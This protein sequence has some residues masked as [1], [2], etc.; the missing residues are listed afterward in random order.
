MKK[1]IFAIVM[2]LCLVISA[3]QVFELSFEAH[4]FACNCGTTTT[5]HKAWCESLCNCSSTTA[6]S[7]QETCPAYRCENAAAA[8]YMGC[9]E[10]ASGRIDHSRMCRKFIQACP[11]VGGSTGCTYTNGVWDHKIGCPLHKRN[12]TDT[13]T[14][15]CMSCGWLFGEHYKYCIYHTGYNQLVEVINHAIYMPAVYCFNDADNQTAAN[16]KPGANAASYAVSEIPSVAASIG[17]NS[18]DVKVIQDAYNKSVQENSAL[19]SVKVTYRKLATY[20][21]YPTDGTTGERIWNNIHI[22]KHSIVVIDLNGNRI[23]GDGKGPVI[24]N[25]GTLIILDSRPTITC[26]GV[27]Q[28]RGYYYFDDQ[29]G[30]YFHSVRNAENAVWSQGHGGNI[31]I[32]G[33]LI[34]GGRTTRNNTKNGGTVNVDA[35]QTYEELIDSSSGTTYGVEK[36]Y[37][38]TYL[39]ENSLTGSRYGFGGGGIHNE[40][41]VIMNGGNIVGCESMDGEGAAINNRGVN[42]KFVMNDGNI[43]YNYGESIIHAEQGA[44]IEINSGKIFRNVGVGNG[45]VRGYSPDTNADAT[46][47]IGQTTDTA[48]YNQAILNNLAALDQSAIINMGDQ[49]IT[50]TGYTGKA[51]YLT[52]AQA[53]QFSTF[54]LTKAEVPL[55]A[56]NRSLAEI[57]TDGNGAGIYAESCILNLNAAII[58][59]N[60]AHYRGGGLDIFNEGDVTLSGNIIIDSNY[61]EYKGGGI[62]VREPSNKSDELYLK[63]TSDTVKVTNNIAAYGGGIYLSYGD[64]D[65]S[66]GK[67]LNNRSIGF[68]MSTDDWNYPAYT[69]YPMN[70]TNLS[71]G[72]KTVVQAIAFDGTVTDLSADDKKSTRHGGGGIFM[73]G[74]IN[75]NAT[76]SG[77]TTEISGNS[78]YNFGGGM[79]LNKGNVIMNG[80]LFQGNY[81]SGATIAANSGTTTKGVD[82]SKGGGLCIQDGSFKMNGGK[83]DGNHVDS[84]AGDG[85][86]IYV[87]AYSVAQQY[88]YAFEIYGGE[89]CNN[90]NEDD[91]GGG[92]M[93]LGNVKM[94]ATDP[95]KP[96]LVYDNTSCDNGGGFYVTE[97]KFDMY[98]GKIY[99]NTAKNY[100]GGGVYVHQS[101]F[102]MF[103]GEIYDNKALTRNGGGVY[104]RNGNFSMTSGK[105]YGNTAMNT[106]ST[107]TSSTAVG[108]QF[109]GGG[110]VCVQNGTVNITGDSQIYNNKAAYKG[111]AIYTFSSAGINTVSQTRTVTIGTTDANATQPKIYGNSVAFSGFVGSYILGG[112]GIC[113]EGKDS[114]LIVN[115]AEI[116]NNIVNAEHSDGGAILMLEGTTDASNTSSEQSLKGTSTVIINNVNAHHN[117]S[118]NDHGGFLALKNGTVTINDGKFYN[119]SALD[120]GGCIY[121]SNGSLTI[122]A[123]KDG[124]V[125]IYNNSATSYVGGAVYLENGII[126]MYG[127]NVYNNKVIN[128]QVTTEIENRGHGGAFDMLK[129]TFRMYNGAIY[130]NIA[131]EQVKG[132]GGAISVRDT[133]DVYI[134]GGKIGV[135]PTGDGTT[136]GNAARD[137]GAIFV[138]SGNIYI[139]K[140]TCDGSTDDF[141]NEQEP[142]DSKCGHPIIANN[143]ATSDG[144]A[145]YSAS[146]TTT[147]YCGEMT[148]NTAANKGGGMYVEGGDIRIENGKVK[149]NESERGEAFGDSLYMTGGD[150]TY[151]KVGTFG[152]SSGTTTGV[153]V[154]GGNLTLNT[155]PPVDSLISV[156]FKD[157]TTRDVVREFSVP[158]GTEII[159][160]EGTDIF[161]ATLFPNQTF[162]GWQ[163]P[164]VDDFTRYDADIKFAG[165]AIIAED[166][167]ATSGGDPNTMTIFGVWANDVNTISYYKTFKESLEYTGDGYTPSYNYNPTNDNYITLPSNPTL[168][169]G[170]EFVNWTIQQG[171]DC[172]PMN[173]CNANWGIAKDTITNHNGGTMFNTKGKFGNVHFYANW[174]SEITYAAAYDDG[175][176]IVAGTTGGT[177]S[178]ASDKVQVTNTATAVNTV[179]ATANTN[180][181]FIGWYYDAACTQ[182]AT[183]DAVLD[184]KALDTDYQRSGFYGDLKYYAKFELQYK[185]LIIK[186]AGADAE[187][188][189]VF[190]VEG[191]DG[192]AKNVNMQVI[193]TTGDNGI[194]TI[195]NIP[196][197]RYKVYENNV[198]STHQGDT[199]TWRYTDTQVKEPVV[200]GAQDAAESAADTVTFVYYN[201]ENNSQPGNKSVNN[202]LNGLSRFFSKIA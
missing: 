192:Y 110:G 82:D 43:M 202:W 53:T 124:D 167:S 95:A 78:A 139:G 37:Y 7:H 16:L 60:W 93:V 48:T 47:T 178:R 129:G 99:N 64:F 164:T 80:G 175:N 9:K 91:Q 141:H 85:G 176:G 72:G 6:G 79:Y 162:I 49:I 84:T 97:G 39:V 156:Y 98:A 103:G 68:Y 63:I 161:D 65:M 196:A 26:S 116:N 163:Y 42:A 61:C 180:Y 153:V 18:N 151:T 195:K 35:G 104:V 38:F 55:I 114:K 133:G 138:S 74:D 159:L 120:N 88:A 137:G 136:G 125:D 109:G 81:L 50:G 198:P 201:G 149:G 199:W 15:I 172:L 122:D 132:D 11:G 185:D 165:T 1:R 24:T 17:L 75:T 144:G 96:P 148:A 5:T 134:Y 41:T 52:S 154:A 58:I 184:P 113:I 12:T 166:N 33:G 145:L 51:D 70:G 169:D 187:Q 118:Q 106:S 90:S 177:V 140:Q 25:Y 155:Q 66:A 108:T 4:A 130:N 179:T 102:N 44:K 190:T 83:F 71:W 29:D 112:G 200:N 143:T 105:I 174:K 158:E 157:R 27:L 20:N 147:F 146:G 86:G 31:N 32:P 36:R 101:N 76:I 111:G 128:P 40:G 152:N 94:D 183:T 77:T 46:V 87:T 119:N 135:D 168:V 67:V 181:T 197:G 150:V 193:I 30:K 100:I 14:T 123:D 191:Q 142:K 10:Q 34:G 8:T 121:Q 73:E 13:A 45:A 127:G 89:I 170:Y 117:E 3:F 92:V 131:G 186:T 188:T 57:Q 59:K 28:D 126:D 194:A 160:P 173:M 182:L 54:H 69:K 22:P 23:W 19:S 171:S 189:F 115:N 107:Q 21:T 56:Y 2:C 62:A